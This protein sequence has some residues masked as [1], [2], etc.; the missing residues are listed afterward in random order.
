MGQARIHQPAL[1]PVHTLASSIR[2]ANLVE[3]RLSS[4]DK[5]VRETLPVH[6]LAV[7][8]I[9]MLAKPHFIAMPFGAY[10]LKAGTIRNDNRLS[11]N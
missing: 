3:D 4:P 7:N 6:R 1:L 2:G 11:A 10:H 8:V 9:R 5:L